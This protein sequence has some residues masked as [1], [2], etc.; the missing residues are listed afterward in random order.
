MET[1]HVVRFASQKHPF[2]LEA[3]PCLDLD[4]S[5][6]IISLKFSELVPPVS[7]PCERLTFTLRVCL[8]TW[9]EQDPPPRSLEVETLVHE[10]LARFPRGRIQE[11]AEEFERTRAV[12]RRIKL[13]SLSGARDELVTYSSVLDERGG[14]REGITDWAYFFMFEG[15]EFLV[16]DHYCANPECDCQLVHLEFWE[17]VHE[18]YPKR[19][20]R[21][22]QQIMATFTLAGELQ[23]IRFS[24]DSPSTTEHLLRAWLRRCSSHFQECRR[25]NEII[26]TVGSRSFP[27]SKP[28]PIVT[29][30][31]PSRPGKPAIQKSAPQPVRRNDPC[32]C[33]SGLK[34]KRCCAR[35]T[36]VVD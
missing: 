22:R 5:C 20:L 18:V 16:E 30:D 10:F 32:P 2:L 15:R 23:E 12:E 29:S 4:C 6:S 1:G 33:G 19:C 21:I 25:R 9:W 8:R 14:V 35:R 7:A 17:R 11:L 36:A 27:A 26:R 34:F 28:Q 31:K 13:L 3:M 24:E